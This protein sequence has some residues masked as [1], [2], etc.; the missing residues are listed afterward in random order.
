MDKFDDKTNSY[1]K[2]HFGNRLKKQLAYQNISLNKFCKANE[3]GR[4]TM[5]KYIRGEICPSYTR[6][7]EISKALHVPFT[8][9]TEDTFVM[10]GHLYAW[11]NADNLKRIKDSNVSNKKQIVD[12]TFAKCKTL[13]SN[14][15]DNLDYLLKKYPTD[16]KRIWSEID[17]TIRDAENK[18]SRIVDKGEKA[19]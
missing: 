10:H 17:R 7:R 11:D 5:Y 15:D 12:Y 6:V 1:L 16:Y 13:L 19:N 18:I 14:I 4:N 3:I 8:L 9:F 2:K